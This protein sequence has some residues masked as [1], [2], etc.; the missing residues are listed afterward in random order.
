MILG[1]KFM[2]ENWK[3]PSIL[4]KKYAINKIGSAGLN[5][6]SWLDVDAI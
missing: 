1:V 5:R 2:I 6:N 4:T 3:I